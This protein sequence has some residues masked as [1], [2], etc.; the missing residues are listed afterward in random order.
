MNKE[1]KDEI[2]LYM[3]QDYEIKKETSTYYELEKNTSS[4]FGHVVVFIFFGWW[5]FL[6]PNLVYYLVSYKKHKVMK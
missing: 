6:I 5:M 3:S 1:I 4:L 2:K